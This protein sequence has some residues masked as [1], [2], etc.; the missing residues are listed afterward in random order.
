M[1]ERPKGS[2]TRYA[3]KKNSKKQ[4]SRLGWIWGL[5]LLVFAG[6]AFV[7]VLYLGYLDYNVRNQFEGKRWAIPARVYANPVDL[8]AGNPISQGRFLEL[9]KL[10][11]YRQDKKLTV[12]GSYYVT[13]T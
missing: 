13:G 9:L 4:G 3:S 1:A 2:G 10:L 6:F 7:F 8:Y 11:H 5:L 12:E